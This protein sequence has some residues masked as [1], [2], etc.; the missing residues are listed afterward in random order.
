MFTLIAGLLTLAALFSYLNVR[1]FRLPPGILFM[2]LGTMVGLGI[3][4]ASQYSDGVADNVRQELGQLNF[5]QF[6]MGSVLSFLLFAGSLHISAHEL[7]ATAVSITAFATV[8]VVLTTL[9]GGVGTYY[10]LQLFD[11]R[12]PLLS[13][14]VFGAL[15]APTDP[16]A[17]LSI[18][19][20]AKLARVVEINLVGESLFNDGVGVVIFTTLIGI[21][22]TTGEPPTTLD[23]VLLLAREALGGL[24]MG[25]LIGYV[26]YR[27][28]KSI[29]HFQTEILITLAM[30]MGGYALCHSL[31]VSGPLA[32]VVAGVFT[33][34][35]SHAEAWSDIT[36]DY[37]GKFWE[38]IDDVLN[39]L[40][41]VLLGLELVVVGLHGT[42]FFLGLLMAIILVGARYVALVVPATVLRLQQNLPPHS[43]KILTWGGLRGG[44]SLALALGLPAG[45]HREVFVPM[46]LAVVLFSIVVQGITLEKVIAWLLRHPTT[47][48]RP[49]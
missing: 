24:L 2:L 1:L 14:L 38:V 7:R 6:L 42:Y 35:R 23:V 15:L 29:D 10:L 37:V 47:S 27:L 17:V 4:L 49:E 25:W 11:L 21:A 33:G 43:L 40:L 48:P 20:K 8:G 22:T 41:F 12:V 32:M 5:T 30:V 3:L 39:A 28:M 18:L 19:K 36:R 46:T 16:V 31:H 9:L 45:L 44:I 26:G 13:C 34:N